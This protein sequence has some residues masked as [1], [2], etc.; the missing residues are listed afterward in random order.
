[1]MKQYLTIKNR[2]RDA[3]LF[4]RMGDFYEMF[5]EDAKI[6]SRILDIALTSRQKE[7]ENPIPMCGVPYHA[8]DSY[9]AKLVEAGYKVAIC[10]QVEDPRKAK[11]LVRREIVRII[12]PGTI[13]DSHQLKAKENQYIAAIYPN[14]N[15]LGLALLD[16]TT[17]EFLLTEF[18][19]ED[20]LELFKD[21]FYR[22]IPREVLLYPGIGADN[23]LHSFLSQE[24]TFLVTDLE[25]GIFEYERAY[26]T[27]L[28]HFQT[29]TLEGF[30]CQGYS[31]AIRAAGALIHYLRETQ[32]DRLTHINKIT[33]YNPNKYMILDLATQRNLELIRSLD[34]SNPQATLLTT[35]DS[36][37]T[38]MG[39]RRLKNWLL[40]PLIDLEAIEERLQGVEAFFHDPINNKQV[41]DLLKGIHDLERLSSKIAL[42]SA[43][44]R[45]LI[46]LK[47][48]LAVL[49]QLETLLGHHQAPIIKGICQDWDNL[50]E[51]CQLIESAIEEEVPPNWHEGGIIKRGFNREL[52][53]LRDISQQGKDWIVALEEKERARTKINT[54]KIGYNKVFGYYIEVTKKYSDQ[55]PPDYI[56]RQ[57]LVNAERYIT[58][59][60][61]EWEEKVLG[62]EEKILELEEALF[63]QVRDQVAGYI[64]QIQKMAQKIATIDVLAALAQV[65]RDKNYVRPQ[66][67]ENDT[68]IIK[69][70]RHPVL[71]TLPLGERFIPNDTYLN[72]TDSQIMLITGPNMAGKSTYLRQVALIVLLAQ[73]GSYVPAKEANIGVVDRIFTRIGAQDY[74]SRGQSTF[75]VEM[76]ETANILNNAT[77]K[78]LIILDEIGRGTSTYDGLSL[79]WAI[80]E[81]IHQCVGAKTLF[82]THYHELTS[83]AQYLPRIKNY[84]VAVREWGGKVIFLRKIVEGA[85]D[86]SYGLQVARLAGIPR[87]ILGRAREILRQLEEGNSDI[88]RNRIIRPGKGQPWQLHLFHDR[89]DPVKKRLAEIDINS[90]TPLE[91]LKTLDELKGMLKD[92]Q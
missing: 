85:T 91:A 3:I 88:Y 21:E 77:W 38:A 30:G 72:N 39:G 22:F 73:I 41:R 63:Q 42:N 26:Q 50:E 71:E 53:Q 90:L 89:P 13:L 47:N 48:S 60:L 6:A 46:M 15:I 7:A 37:V 81:H 59:E 68:I 52:D 9:V 27:L 36:T 5:Y 44:P 33:P 24:P 80:M 4:F 32:G 69:E 64:P 79:A 43:T 45:E 70:G 75:L 40:H 76:N 62:A 49:P 12:T 58:P 92:G 67:N 51:I 17:G 10:E 16:H 35:I 54:L 66:F 87:E 34:P 8:A 19:G 86:R 61:K 20:R 56:R 29:Q 82:A 1:M 55:I 65:A 14:T 78:S 28:D 31:T 84:N 11:G 83:L 74:L 57:T 25:E 2:L 18:T 23:P